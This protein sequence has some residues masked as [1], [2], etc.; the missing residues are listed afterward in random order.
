MVLMIPGNTWTCQ[1]GRVVAPSRWRWLAASS[2]V[3]PA[4]HWS[5]TTMSKNNKAHRKAKKA[6]QQR[7][8]AHKPFRVKAASAMRSL[9]DSAYDTERIHRTIAWA[10]ATTHFASPAA[11]QT[12]L[13]DAMIGDA[14][15]P[16]HAQMLKA[17]VEEQA[18][19]LAFQALDAWDLDE[20]QDLAKEALELDPA[21]LDALRVLTVDDDD[22]TAV[23][24]LEQ[25]LHQEATRPAVAEALAIRDGNAWC[26][27]SARPT[28]RTLIALL[29][30]PLEAALGLEIFARV[31][32]YDRSLLDQVPMARVI[33]WALEMH[34]LSEA[35]QHLDDLNVEQSLDP[36]LIWA[37]GL[38][39]FLAGDLTGAAVA[40][41]EARENRDTGLWDLLIEGEDEALD[42]DDDDLDLATIGRAWLAHP[43]ALGWLRHEAAA[44]QEAVD[45]AAQAVYGPPLNALLTL[46]MSNA[47]E[48]SRDGSWYARLGLDS[49]HGPTLA[50][51]AGDLALH[52]HPVTDPVIWAPIHAIEALAHLATPDHLPQIMALVP[53][54]H[55]NEWMQMALSKA[56]VRQGTAAVEPL[57]TVA[58][59]VHQSTSVRIFALEVLTELVRTQVD[60]RPRVLAWL[61]PR[62]V[63][64]P[65]EF[66]LVLSSLAW[67]AVTAKATKHEDVLR[68]WSQQGRLDDVQVGNWPAL[69]GDL[70][71]WG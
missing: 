1:G 11:L 36:A 68:S 64:P 31:R 6:K 18:Q 8:Q 32:A 44:A 41:D 63:H 10:T 65:S 48:R 13:D 49:S 15:K 5:G 38:E 59:D 70:H 23:E 26:R 55:G 39:R 71:R 61:A 34:D 60:Q 25:A 28:L 2:A 42:P 14:W 35:R 19:E 57:T 20:A 17:S 46:G 56:L 40:F 45:P 3:E 16:T 66:R 54:W 27:V 67:L 52:R 24:R 29:E 21:N 43:A 53:R 33:G 47:T 62:L 30:R 12:W 37:R 69:R 50:R 4:D 9:P 22:Q 58:G 7:R 51:M